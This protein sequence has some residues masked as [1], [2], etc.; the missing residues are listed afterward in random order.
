MPNCD[1]L[2]LCRG[3]IANEIT[4]VDTLGAGPSDFD[5]FGSPEEGTVESFTTSRF[6]TGNCVR[7]CILM[8]H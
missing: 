7:F 4:L 2:V 6:S 5:G 3:E 8:A 1:S